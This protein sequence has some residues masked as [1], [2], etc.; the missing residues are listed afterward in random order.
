MPTPPPATS[1]PPPV[2][3][4]GWRHR[5][6]AALRRRRLADPRLWWDFRRKRFWALAILLTYTV[7]GFLVAPLLIRRQVVDLAQATF[8]RPATL[9]G[10]SVNPYALSVELRGFRLTEADGGPLLGFD[11]LYVRLAPGGLLR[12]AWGIAD[13]QVQGLRAT[14]VRYGQTDTNIGRLIQAAAGDEAPAKAD[15]QPNGESSGLPRLLIRHV[16]IVDAAADVT[17][18]VPGTPFKTKVGPVSM[19]FNDLSTLPE[20][21]GRQHVQV[22]LEGGATLEWTGTSSLNPVVSAGHVAARGPYIPLL[23]RYFGDALPVAVPTGTIAA[24]LD[25]QLS[26]GVRRTVTPLPSVISI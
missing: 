26:R 2:P 9:D 11:R 1:T 4:G 21:Q 18:Q 22:G 15:G 6:G 25:Y 19:E 7:A 24:D 8:Q 3:H 13:I 5:L 17:D 16:T 14:V 12:W 20:R 10:V 23:A